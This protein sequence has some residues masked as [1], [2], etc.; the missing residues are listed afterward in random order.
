MILIDTPT[1]YAGVG[2]FSHMTGS[3][4]K[5]LHE[6]AKNVGIKRCWFSN[7]RGKNQPHYDVNNRYYKSCI[8]AGAKPVTNFELKLFINKTFQTITP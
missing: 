3:S 4:V 5:E 2:T 8:D 7:K 6:F 1:K